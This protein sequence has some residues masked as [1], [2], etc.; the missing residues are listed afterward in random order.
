MKTILLLAHDDSGQEA[1]FQAAVDL[2]RAVDGHLTCLDVAIMPAMI[3]SDYVGDIGAATLLADE[4]ARESANRTHLEFRLMHEDVPWD[5]IE[6]TG[7]IGPCLRSA[8][9]L[10]DLI[11]VNRQLDDFPLP[12]MRGAASA[13]IIKSGKPLLAVPPDLLRFDHARAV[14]AWDGSVFAAAALRAAVPL[15]A[16]AEQVTILQ[17]GAAASDAPV[18]DAAAYL[19]RYGIRTSVERQPR[20]ETRIADQIVERALALGAGYIVM[21]GFGHLRFVEALFGGTTRALLAHSP[22]PLFLA[23]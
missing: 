9:A 19:S 11:V 14:I 20:G 17:L 1:R 5:W 4:V 6:A 23:H 13:L 22:L 16:F 12:D 15:L 2:V 21:G 8:S 3:A 18:E 10:A 7:A